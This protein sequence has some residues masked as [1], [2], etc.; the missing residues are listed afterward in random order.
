MSNVNETLNE[1]KATHKNSK[2]E[3]IPNRFSKKN[4][5]KLMKS[6]ANDPS[7][8]VKIPV[9]KDGEKDHLEDLMVTEGFRKWC[10]KLLEKAGVDKKESAMVLDASF[11]ID[12]M[13]GLYEFFATALYEYMNA[14]NRF[15]MIPR[16][17]FKGSLSVVK[18][19]KDKK[20]RESRDPKTGK[21]LGMFEYTNE[22]YKSV[23]SSSPCPSYLK[24]RKKIK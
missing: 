5:S 18:K 23:V 20:I 22:S 9:V 11:E 2:G 6:M 12:T 3:I 10:R 14:G 15:D 13:D 16:E 8:V 24:G 7:F 19:P 1:I 4:F 21:S 17:D